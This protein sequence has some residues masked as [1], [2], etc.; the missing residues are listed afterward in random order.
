[1]KVSVGAGFLC[2]PRAGQLLPPASAGSTAGGSADP[3]MEER[4][5]EERRPKTFSSLAMRWAIPP[6]PGRSSGMKS[7]LTSGVQFC[8]R[9]F[10]VLWDEALS[11]KERCYSKRVYYILKMAELHNIESFMG[12][13]KK[14]PRLL[15]LSQ[16]IAALK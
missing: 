2:P 14:Q 13:E 1:M 3:A 16:I 4:R 8:S 9:N 12:G 6:Q 11:M 7:T 15:S 5:G 10:K